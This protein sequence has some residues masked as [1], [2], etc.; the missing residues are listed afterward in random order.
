VLVEAQVQQKFVEVPRLENPLMPPIDVGDDA[1]PTF[2]DID[3]DG[4][5]D[6]FIGGKTRVKYYENIGNVNHPIFEERTDE[7]SPFN[8]VILESRRSPTLVDIDNDGDFDAFIGGKDGAIR[9]YENTGTVSKS[10]FVEHTKEKNPLNGVN[11]SDTV[12]FFVDIDGDSDLDVFIGTDEIVSNDEDNQTS[13][14]Y[15]IVKYFENIDSINNPKFEERSETTYSFSRI[16]NATDSTPHFADIDN[17]GDMDAFIGSSDGTVR[18]YENTGTAKKPRF[19]EPQNNPLN[20]V[21]VGSSSVLIDSIGSSSA[22][23]LIDIDGDSDLDA[24]IGAGDGT[25]KYHENIGNSKEPNFVERTKLD[26]PFGGLVDNDISLTLVDI[27]NDGDLDAFAVQSTESVKYYK[28]TGNINS[29]SFVERIEQ[30]NPLDGVKGES[31]SSFDTPLLALLDI[32]ADGDLDAFIGRVVEE[33]DEEHEEITKTYAYG[34]VGTI[35]YYENIG[36]ASQPK[37]KERIDDANPFNEVKIVD[38]DQNDYSLYFVNADDDLD[39]DVFINRDYYENIGSISQPLFIKRLEQENPV[40]NIGIGSNDG[41][42]T[43]IDINND[44]NLDAFVISGGTVRYYENN[45]RSEAYFMEREKEQN[46]FVDVVGIED[47]SVPILVDLDNDGDLDAFIK[48]S[49]SGMVKYYQNT[50]NVNQLV[51]KFNGQ[52]N[53]FVELSENIAELG[54]QLFSKPS[55]VDIDNDGDLDTFIGTYEGTVKYYENT[56]NAGEPLFVERFKQENPLSSVFVFSGSSTPT[57]VDFDNDGDLDAFIGS[58]QGTVSYYENWGSASEPRFVERQEQD[59]PLSDVA[60]A[61][62]NDKAGFSQVTLVDIDNDNDLDAFIGSLVG[63]IE[64]YENTGNISNPNF[65][66]QTEDTNPLAEVSIRNVENNEGFS[67]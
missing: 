49:T 55:L 27:D 15:G 61:C 41:T 37:F 67:T 32:D 29:P 19:I 8:E 62:L 10:T 1:N 56:G 16:E 38:N 12:P 21:N 7:N 20:D 4:D 57:L 44:G 58:R 3:N 22:P 42:H 47:D 66:K 25:V 13:M 50:S 53:F 36:S 60:V 30:D 65:V 33:Q 24:F 14:S 52:N 39:F 64:Y 45:G 23:A 9:Y 43:L 35:K 17:D 59:N 46:P 6:V 2:A 28:N 48:A 31:A 34:T 40:S 26:N 63:F 54:E 5:F 18:Y 11:E 51:F